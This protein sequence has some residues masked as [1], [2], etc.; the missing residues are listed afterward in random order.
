MGVISP[1][2]SMCEGISSEYNVTNSWYPPAVPYLNTVLNL[3]VEPFSSSLMLYFLV[4]WL[5]FLDSSPATV[6]S[7]TAIALPS[8]VF[9]T[10]E[11][12]SVDIYAVPGTIAESC[13]VDLAIPK[14]PDQ[15]SLIETSSISK[16]FHNVFRSFWWRIILSAGHWAQSICLSSMSSF[17]ACR[18]LRP[19]RR[20]LVR[21]CIGP[22]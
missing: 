19:W 6:H 4:V 9:I 18:G 1:V 16:L 17:R 15:T 10:Q 11:L 3:L 2:V 14:S 12:P 22:L 7:Y 8:T 13:S 20:D 5:T 21:T